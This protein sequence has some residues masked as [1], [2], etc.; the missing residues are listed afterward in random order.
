MILALSG[1]SSRVK[2]K[3]VKATFVRSVKR[4]LNSRRMSSEDRRG[5][6]RSVMASPL[7]RSVFAF[8]SAGRNWR[9]C[10]SIALILAFWDLPQVVIPMPSPIS[11][12]KPAAAEV[13]SRRC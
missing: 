7:V 5:A 4:V 11:K 13:T 3:V 9:I 12:R 8:D 10:W 2:L 1:S 6:N